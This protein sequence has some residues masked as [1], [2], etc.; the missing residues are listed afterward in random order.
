MYL[1]EMLMK[2]Y[3]MPVNDVLSLARK[4]FLVFLEEWILE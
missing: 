4:S 3:Q 2:K 1:H